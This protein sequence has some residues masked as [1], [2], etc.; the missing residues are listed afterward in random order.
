MAGPH[1]KKHLIHQAVVQRTTRSQAANGEL[2]DSWAA[3]G[4]IDIRYVQNAHR[5]ADEQMGYPMVLEHFALCNS[6][7]DVTVEDRLVNVTLKVDGSTVN[8]GPFEINGVLGRN[9][10]GPHHIRLNLEKIE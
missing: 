2:I 1:F 4:T 6:D 10:T 7:E 3:V 5:I 8:A 9:S